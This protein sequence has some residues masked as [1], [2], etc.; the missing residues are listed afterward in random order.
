MVH[1]DADRTHWWWLRQKCLLYVD[2]KRRKFHFRNQFGLFPYYEAR[3]GNPIYITPLYNHVYI[4]CRNVLLHLLTA[5]RPICDSSGGRYLHIS[6]SDKHKICTIILF[7][8]QS[9][10]TFKITQKSCPRQ[11]NNSPCSLRHISKF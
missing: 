11:G 9:S 4:H 1:R 10:P 7:C 8:T 6:P 5:G 2:I 3:Y